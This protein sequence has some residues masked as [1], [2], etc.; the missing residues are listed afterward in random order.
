MGKFDITEITKTTIT[1]G[2]A[3]KII[4]IYGT[5]NT[6]K[7]Y[8]SAR[9]F[10]DKTLWL[11]T[12]KGYNAQSDL[13]VYD[14]E[15]WHDFRDA[16]NQLT[17][18]NKKKREKVREMYDCVVVD[19]AD[20]IPNLCTQYIISR[21]NEEQSA[22]F[23]DFNPINEISAI[24]FG[25]GY[26]SLNR[27]IDIQI[28][29]L[30]LSGYCV[31]LIFHDEIKT[32]KDEKNR[33]YEYIIPKTTFNK[34]GNCLKDIPDFMIYLELQGIGDDGIPILSRGH[35]VQHKEFFARSRYTECQPI[36]DPFTGENLKNAI[37]LA[38]EKEAEKLGVKAITFAEEES[39]KE[40]VKEEKSKTYED[41]KNMIQ[42][43][44]KA[45]YTAKYKNFVDSVV[46][47]YLGENKK[48]SQTTNEDK[49]SLQY[50]YDKL[51]DFAEEKNVDWE[52]S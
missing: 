25:G 5:N 7:S 20:K 52:E 1:T 8:V 12:E 6:G 43:I 51:L 14:I 35:C 18:R 29:K 28:N 33:E 27:E 41:L 31:V 15:N 19:T 23:T 3:G 39:K 21:Y 2:L 11:A 38:C 30:A 32:M 37:K 26:A 49:D 9:L 40:K 44:Y 22:N 42:P 13:Y 48:I 24:P 34:A 16:I 47:Q 4:G 36:I 50:I 17:T 45:L 10:P 46:T